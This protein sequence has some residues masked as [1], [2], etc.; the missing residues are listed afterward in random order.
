MTSAR[1]KHCLSIL[2]WRDADLADASG[3]RIGEVRTWLDGRQHP[4][5]AVTAW[6]EALVKAYSAVPPLCNVHEKSEKPQRL[7]VDIEPPA[8]A[9]DQE[10]RRQP[11]EHNLF[12]HPVTIVVGLGFPTEV[13]SVTDAIA[14]LYEWPP[15]K[16]DS[17]H[18]VALNACKAALAGEIEADTARGMF[19]A[20]ARRHD[21]LAPR[22]ENVIPAASI[23]EFGAATMH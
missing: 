20:F 18:M 3:Y 17:A 9:F 7:A 16:R 23:G 8:K 19:V 21:L 2:R 4:P 12:E 5:L 14:V 1:L 10:R 15:S 6:L 13:K 22:S 11:M